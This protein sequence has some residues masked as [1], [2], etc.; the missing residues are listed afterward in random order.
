MNNTTTQPMTDSAIADFFARSLTRQVYAG[1]VKTKRRR[2]SNVTFC[3][4][5]E[6]TAQ[7]Q[8]DIM[9]CDKRRGR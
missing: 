7:M 5:D 9:W 4:G 3:M 6:P 2:L 8:H 1:E